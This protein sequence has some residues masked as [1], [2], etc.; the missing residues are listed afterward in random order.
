[1]IKGNSKEILREVVLKPRSMRYP[2]KYSRVKDRRAGQ[3]HT[4]CD[5]ILLITVKKA[6]ELAKAKAE[7][8]AENDVI[9][10]FV[11]ESSQSQKSDDT[12]TPS[13]PPRRRM[14]C[15]EERHKVDNDGNND[16]TRTAT[17]ATT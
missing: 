3:K 8:E 9:D 12:P 7:L 2:T 6:K 4:Q 17:M 16:D 13:P 15:L 5:C 1:M 11:L 14:R 10:L